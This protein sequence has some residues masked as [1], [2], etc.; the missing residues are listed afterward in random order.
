MNYR[1]KLIVGGVFL[2]LAM[3]AKPYNW[4]NWLSLALGIIYVAEGWI[5]GKRL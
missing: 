1:L 4:S 3:A 2:A 5:E